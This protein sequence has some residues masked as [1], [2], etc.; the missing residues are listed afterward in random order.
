VNLSEKPAYAEGIVA[1][2]GKVWCPIKDTLVKKMRDNVFMFIFLQ[3]SGRR[4][5]VE[6]GPWK[7]GNDLLVV[8][9]FVPEKS[10]DDYAFP[11]FPILGPH[12]QAT[13]G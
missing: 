6:D 8:E 13:T 2:L 4:K 12:L 11:M 3:P 1:S 9:E 5:A 10:L 7:V